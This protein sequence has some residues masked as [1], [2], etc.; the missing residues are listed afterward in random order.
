MT[1][2]SILPTEALKKDLGALLDLDAA[3]K[4]LESAA[5][6]LRVDL[7]LVDAGHRTLVAVSGGGKPSLEDLPAIIHVCD[8]LS[9]EPLGALRVTGGSGGTGGGLRPEAMRFLEQV[10]SALGQVA[11]HERDARQRHAEL[12]TIYNTS[13]MLAESRDLNSVLTRTVR[14]V[15]EVIGVKG[16]SIRLV[17]EERDELRFV[18]VHGLS[19]AYLSSAPLRLSRAA[20][21]LAAMKN[22]H[23]QVLD[24]RGDQ[25]VQFPDV[26]AA[27]GIVS[28]LSV[29]MRY[30]GQAIGVLRAYTG[31]PRHFS[32][33][34][35]E[36]I[37]AVASQSA[38][39]IV[40][41]RLAEESAEAQA[42]EKQVLVAAD[43]QQRMIPP[44]PPQSNTLQFASAYT[45]CFELAGDLCD[46]MVLGDE[47]IGVVIADVAGKG[48]PAS[49]I[50][51]TVRAYIR[52]A[53][54]R[55]D[56]LVHTL[57]GLNAMLCRDNRPGEFVSLF[58][59][60]FDGRARTLD[61]VLAGHAPPMLLRGGEVSVASGGDAVLGVIPDAVYESRR[62]ALQQSDALLLYTD[63]LDEARNFKEEL[64]GQERV[65]QSFAQPAPSAEMI[66]Q[67]VI[68]DMHRFVGL[69]RR[70]DDV[71]V[72]AVRV[73]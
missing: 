27:E 59:G 2:S 19:Q 44:H 60:I 14:L 46:F 63:G 49:L 16:A 52:A 21:D 73:L 61:Y 64:Y 18:A 8:S 38:A 25:R 51:A 35:I 57:A 62:L 20:I 69:Q 10:A 37:A 43:V 23:E 12:M 15:S 48:V 3:R 39:A 41:T 17:D 11:A 67:N 71:T 5:A 66:V 34:E 28:V 24:L 53:S 68:W 33:D 13:M 72:I 47:R 7:E 36:L 4:L 42:L 6:V 22:G 26:L 56:T 54:E 40:N 58:Y 31:E 70:T 45:P 55:G 65:R 30:K 9:R 1:I 29:P 32:E 50:M